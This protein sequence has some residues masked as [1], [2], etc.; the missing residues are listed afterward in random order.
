MGL[1]PTFGRWPAILAP[2]AGRRKQTPL[3]SAGRVGGLSLLPS[4]GRSW[5]GL[6][7]PVSASREHHWA[8][9]AS[10][11]LGS[12]PVLTLPNSGAEN[13]GGTRAMAVA[14]ATVLRAADAVEAGARSECGCRTRREPS[15]REVGGGAAGARRLRG[16][17]LTA[18]PPCC[19]GDCRDRLTCTAAALEQQLPEP[20]FAPALSS[21]NSDPA[22]ASLL[23]SHKHDRRGLTSKIHP[24]L[25]HHVFLYS[26]FHPDF[27]VSCC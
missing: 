15:R 9:P 14:R 4:G 1:S 26:V 23:A 7:P 13:A 18:T 6:Q 16:A 2:Q 27:S 24:G 19:H 8:Q 10:R 21:R 25:L 17:P 5:P 12:H 11:D 3:Q 20:S 22:P